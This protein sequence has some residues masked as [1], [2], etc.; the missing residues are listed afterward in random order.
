MISG[1]SGAGKSSLLNALLGLAPISSGEILLDGAPLVATQ[2]QGAVSWTGQMTLFLPGT[3]ADNI[4]L[5]RPDASDEDIAAAAASAGLTALIA[6]RPAGLQTP[7]DPRGS[8][9]SGG[10][11]RRIGIARAL[12]RDAPLW[13]LDEPTADLDAASADALIALI[14]SASQGRTVLLVTHDPAVA[15]LSDHHVVIE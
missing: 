11:R 12:L 13:L 15:A 9:L 1:P 3:L 5:A 2:L 7:I 14:R 8:G 10:E 4:R 6:G